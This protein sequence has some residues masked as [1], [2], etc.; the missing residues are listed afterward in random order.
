MTSTML[1]WIAEEFGMVQQLARY[2]LQTV[3]RD[4]PLTLRNAV[5]TRY[6]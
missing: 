1:V 4:M 3:L 5:S 2:V 6:G